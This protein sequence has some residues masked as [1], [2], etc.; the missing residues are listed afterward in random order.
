[1]LSFT[2]TGIGQ[3]PELNNCAT[4]Q[5]AGGGAGAGPA[6]AVPAPAPGEINGIK[7][8]QT[9]F[10]G[11]CSPVDGCEVE[12]KITNTTAELKKGPLLLFH[13]AVL[14]PQEKAIAYGL[15]TLSPLPPQFQ[16]RQ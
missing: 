11:P 6:A 12:I 9:P 4:L 15:E 8:E 7:V 1:P 5:A 14:P 10:P 3:E 16:C 13:T 2:P